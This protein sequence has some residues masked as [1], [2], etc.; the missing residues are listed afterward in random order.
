MPFLRFRPTPGP[1]HRP[2]IG[3]KKVVR[4]AVMIVV[5]AAI[6]RL[7]QEDPEEAKI[8]EDFMCSLPEKVRERRLFQ[9]L[10]MDLRRLKR[11][12]LTSIVQSARPQD[13]VPEPGRRAM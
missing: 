6:E 8:Y 4:A 11:D 10:E 7:A 12:V 1:S 2:G 5:R 13:V 9:R 3:R